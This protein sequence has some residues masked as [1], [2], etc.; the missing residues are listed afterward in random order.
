MAVT[1]CR[2]LNIYVI[3]HTITV[4]DISTQSPAGLLTYIF[5]HLVF[6]LIVLQ[7]LYQQTHGNI[8]ADVNRKQVIF[9]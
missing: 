5:R 9:K 2:M 3:L 6:F 8:D 4:V 7:F 1:Y